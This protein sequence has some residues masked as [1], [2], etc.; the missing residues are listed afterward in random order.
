MLYQINKSDI[1]NS[2]RMPIHNPG[3]FGLKEKDIEEFLTTR[4]HEVIQ[5]D[6]L[7]LIGQERSWQEEAD[8]LALD[9]DGVLYI[10]ELKRWES[11]RENILQVMR[12]GQIFGR[13]SY[14]KLEA[15][16]K[17]Q[18]K[19]EPNGLQDSHKK[20]FELEQ[21][22]SKE[23]F[24]SDQVFVLVTH[25]LDDDTISAVE[26]W[27]KKGVRIECAPYC[28]YSID[29]EPYIQFHT[30]SP[31]QELI[32][33]SNTRIFIVNTN[34]AYMED[35][36]KS[37]LGNS[38]ASAYYDRKYSVTGIQKGDRVYLYHTGEGV[39]AK[40]VATGGHKKTDIN[41][42]SDEEFYVSLDFSKGW[43]LDNSDDWKKAPKA[44]QINQKL[45]TGHRFRQTVFSI[46]EEMAEAMDKIYEIN[47]SGT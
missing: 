13:Y 22:I 38:K 23:K 36:W 6:Q 32:V 24:N 44:W 47:S 10:F 34:K 27:K 29:N 42:D 14:E 45:N 35:A 43:V 46:S 39:I 1:Q 37:M 12:Y 11:N 5:E 25:G 26:Y 15:L 28:V 20:H 40:G 30:Y 8:L 33:E 4:L 9:K 21:A 3:T 31:N 7:L 18:G 2:K 19:L 41:S 17:R 16:S